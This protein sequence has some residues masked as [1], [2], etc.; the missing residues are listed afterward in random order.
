MRGRRK[1]KT[2]TTS[3]RR[4]DRRREI[5]SAM[6]GKQNDKMTGRQ[7]ERLPTN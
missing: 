5:Q 2:N 3:L 7:S 1:E 4:K 6:A